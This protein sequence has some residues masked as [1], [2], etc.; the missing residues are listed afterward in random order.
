MVANHCGPLDI[1]CIIQHYYG[2]M[3]FLAN[4]GL[5]KVPIISFLIRVT[6]GFYA[7]RF[8][9]KDTRNALV[10]LIADRQVEVET[11]SESTKA[12]MI[13]FPEGS[14][15]NNLFLLPFKRGAFMT[16]TTIR[17]LVLKYECS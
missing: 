5:S 17:P 7:P 9:S 2:D 15:Q 3:A 13:I 10:E 14:T 1:L 11:K 4:A 12:P 8:A 6:G 16:E